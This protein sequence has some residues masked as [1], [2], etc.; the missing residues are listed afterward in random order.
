[1]P[2]A[3]GK[4][5]LVAGID[6]GLNT[7]GIVLYR[8]ETGEYQA[9]TVTGEGKASSRLVGIRNGMVDLV[10]SADLVALESYFFSEKT[11]N[12]ACEF[13]ELNG[14]IKVALYEAGRKFIVVPPIWLKRYV[15]GDNRAPKDQITKEVLRRWGVDTMNNHI[16]DSFVL[17][18][19]AAAYL[20]YRKGLTSYQKDVICKL[21]NTV[22]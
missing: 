3:S 18:K 8:P 16:S 11:A 20:G 2:D 19:I 12:G 14:C 17:A 4:A 15:T 21:L 10:K 13:A 1:M 22:Q 6:P 5:K 9:H 7:S